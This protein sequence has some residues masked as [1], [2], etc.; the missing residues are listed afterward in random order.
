MRRVAITTMVDR[1]RE[2]VFRAVGL[3]PVELP[4]IKIEAAHPDVLEEA[5]RQ[6][7]R[8]DLL[9]ATSA[10]TLSLLWPAGE[11]P[12]TPVA[13]VG[14][15]T[16]L[17]VRARGGI[18]ELV[19][20]HGGAASL[21]AEL[22][23]RLAGRLVAFPHAG[24]TDPALIARLSAASGELAALAVYR[25]VPAPPGPDPVEAAAFASPSAVRG[26]LLARPLD[27]LVVGVIGPTTRAEVERRHGPPE[28]EAGVPTFEALAR[29]LADHFQ[30]A[31]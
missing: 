1:C 30:E 4:C 25:T 15:Q 10:H 13:A 31:A 20:R 22:E 5:R 16:A 23:G 7:A 11:M 29:A 2:G 28:V 21:V 26:W 24:G 3:E 17:A 27:G 6:S 9:V 18:V 19:G 12:L 8:S 14:E